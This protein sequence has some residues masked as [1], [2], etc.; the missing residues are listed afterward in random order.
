M[1]IC[2]NCKHHYFLRAD[3]KIDPLTCR[4]MG[5]GDTT[6]YN[7]GYDYMDVD[8]DRLHISEWV[9]VPDNYGCIHWEANDKGKEIMIDKILEDR[10]NTYGSFSHNATVT[11]G[12]K[13]YLRLGNSWKDMSSTQKEALEMVCH[14]MSRIV[15]GNPNY[16]DSWID[17]QGFTELAIRDLKDGK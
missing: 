10:E 3:N 17:I 11:Q 6:E 15:N 13:D 8:G 7:D 5:G 1:K 14:K 16:K 4:L 2:K 12:L 9:S